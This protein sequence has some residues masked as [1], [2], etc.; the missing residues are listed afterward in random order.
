MVV[1]RVAE[2]RILVLEV[3]RAIGFVQHEFE[4]DPVRR[5][6]ETQVVL[7]FDHEASI[8]RITQRLRMDR[9]G[10]LEERVPPGQE[11][12]A[13]RRRRQ[14][15]RAVRQVAPIDAEQHA[16]IDAGRDS[17][18]SG[19]VVGER[20]ADRHG[21]RRVAR[22]IDRERGAGFADLNECVAWTD[23]DSAVEAV[24]EQLVRIVLRNRVAG[25]HRERGPVCLQRLR[26]ERGRDAVVLIAAAG[27]DRLRFEHL[28]ATD[29]VLLGADEG[30]R[31]AG[32][33]GQHVAVVDL[34][35]R[36]HAQAGLV[37]ARADRRVGRQRQCELDAGST[38]GGVGRKQRKEDA[39]AGAMHV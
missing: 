21:R 25:R 15:R 2:R 12:R 3:D 29:I 9:A 39:D 24:A 5:R 7:P 35:A 26:F 6:R 28:E 18:L 16:A 27:R 8:R 19:A 34:G 30:E 17:V 33:V 38:G 20:E 4:R 23:R 32:V 11:R 22:R 14:R 10:R 1:L 37:A 31:L 13:E 36:H